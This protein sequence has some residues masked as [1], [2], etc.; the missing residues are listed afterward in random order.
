MNSLFPL[1][2]N[3]H[4]LPKIKIKFVINTF[5]G[6]AKEL[7]HS[8]TIQ[9]I[10]ENYY[11]LKDLEI[12]DINQELVFDKAKSNFIIFNLKKS[13]QMSENTSINKGNYF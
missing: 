7:K 9:R 8:L 6:N 1:K 3:I 12:L 10:L 2:A 11:Q 5:T 4:N 13:N